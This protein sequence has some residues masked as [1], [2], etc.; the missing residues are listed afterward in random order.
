M[1]LT[2]KKRENIIEAAI[3]EFRT[4]GYL[5]AKTTQIAKKAGVSS[6]TLYNHF[7]S[8]EALFSAICDIMI[9][10]NCV[11]TSVGYDSSRAL[12]E[13]LVDA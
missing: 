8:K 13:Q 9:K 2:E 6:R 11:M 5:G 10:R 3:D 1:K 7:E 4:Q 12:D